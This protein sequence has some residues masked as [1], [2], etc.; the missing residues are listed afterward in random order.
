VKKKDI[1]ILLVVA[2]VLVGGLIVYL[3]RGG[4]ETDAETCGRT[5]Q[6]H[7]VVIQNGK[8]NPV[9]TTAPRC[10][11]LTIINKDDITREIGFGDHD[12]HVPYDGVAQRIL[13]KDE[14]VTV[15]L[16]KTGHYH[17]HDHFHDEV[18]GEFNVN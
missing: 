6:T 15:T 3:M 16:V 5:G 7:T 14:S 8:M 13:H 9:E 18:E 2:V 17:F 12:H 4:T 10:D 11:K 1:L